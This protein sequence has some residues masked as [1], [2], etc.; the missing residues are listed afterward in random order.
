MHT[1]RQNIPSNTPFQRH[2]S[3]RYPT[4][5][6]TQSYKWKNQKKLGLNFKLTS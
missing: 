5:S 2:S 6:V 4:K 1:T 3:Q